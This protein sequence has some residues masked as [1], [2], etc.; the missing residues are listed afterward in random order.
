MAEENEETSLEVVENIPEPVLPINAP[1]MNL[2]QVKACA[3]LLLG[4]LQVRSSAEAAGKDPRAEEI[5]ARVFIKKR[6]RDLPMTDDKNSRDYVLR[7]LYT[8]LDTNF[9]VIFKKIGQVPGEL[10][11]LS[12][13]QNDPDFDELELQ[14]IWA[15]DYLFQSGQLEH[16]WKGDFAVPKTP[17]FELP[18]LE[19]VSEEVERTFM[20]ES[21]REIRRELEGFLSLEGPQ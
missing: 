21:E 6:L 1:F 2:R 15:C 19:D 14:F 13:I 10:A 8:L 11:F 16:A 7:A 12:G 5:T 18:Q 17:E 4:T 20:E 3:Y 9:V